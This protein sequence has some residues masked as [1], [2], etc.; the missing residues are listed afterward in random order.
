MKP[1]YFQVGSP[2]RPHGR[3][4]TAALPVRAAALA[5]AMWSSAAPA[6]EPSAPTPAVD[7][8]PDVVPAADA[9]TVVAPTVDAAPSVEPAAPAEPPAPLSARERLDEA[10]RR[11][12][13]GDWDGAILLARDAATRA[14]DADPEARYLTGIAL[15]GAARPD[16]AVAAFRDLIATYPQSSQALDGSFR[17][18]IVLAD[19]GRYDDA[20]AALDRLRPLKKLAPEGRLKVTLCT[21]TWTLERDGDKRAWKAVE[22]AL[23]KVAPDQLTWFQAL[24]HRALLRRATHGADLVSLDV[25]DGRLDRATTMRGT[26][27]TVAEL[28][29]G[30]IADLHEPRFALDGILELG[31]AYARTGDALLASPT[32]AS[33][34][35]NEADRYESLLR[36]RAEGMWIKASKLYELGLDTAGRFPWAADTVPKLN[37]ANE[38]A[39][40]RFDAE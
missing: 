40:A 28:E 25:A 26:F 30:E 10:W 11:V 22:K 31:L 24:A 36:A 6:R 18:A 39:R 13:R 33:L 2:F 23:T 38:A 37:A 27:L 16:D 8:A 32:P 29:L 7:A 1:T 9:N 4:S 35:G 19:Q 14:P 17:M 20:L 15:S 21:A 5:F 3:I 12:D 34:Q